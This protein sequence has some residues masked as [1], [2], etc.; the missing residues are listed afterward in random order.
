MIDTEFVTLARI[1]ANDAELRGFHNTAR[2]M[3]QVIHDMLN[4]CPHHEIH[5]HTKSSIERVL[6]RQ[7]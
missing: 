5:C 7:N 1:A 4:T 6:S 3:R 2:A